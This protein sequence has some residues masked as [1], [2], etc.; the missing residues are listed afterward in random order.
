[1]RHLSVSAGQ[2]NA[3]L[4]FGIPDDAATRNRTPTTAAHGT[5]RRQTKW[6]N[7]IRYGGLRLNFQFTDFR[8]HWHL[9]S[10]YRPVPRR[11]RHHYRA[12][13]GTASA[14]RRSFNM[15]RATDRPI[16]A[17]TG[18]KQ[19][20]LCLCAV[21]L[22][23]NPHVV[24]LG[25]FKYEDERGSTRSSGAPPTSIER[26]NY[27]YTLQIAGEH[28]QSALLQ[29]RQRP[30]GQ[31]PLWIC[32]HASRV[33]C[34][35][36]RSSFSSRLAK[37]DEAA[38]QLRQRHQGAEHLQ[39]EQSRSSTCC[40][41]LPNG[42]E[43]I[44]QFHVGPIGPENSRTYDGGVDQQ[45]W[46][47]RARLGLTYFHNEFTNGVEYVPQSALLALGFPARAIPPSQYGATINSMAFRAQGAEAELEYK[48]GSHLFA[49]GGYTYLDAVVQRSF[50]SSSAPVKNPGSSFS[51]IPIGQYSPLVGARPFR[52]APHSGYF[53]LNYTRSR[54]YGSL[55]GTLVGTAR[56]QHVSLGRK[57]RREPAPAQPQPARRV[58]A[59]R[60]Q[61][62]LRA[63]PR[64]YCLRRRPESSERT[65]L[66]GLWLSCPAADLPGWPQVQLR[67]R[68]VERSII[69]PKCRTAHRP[70]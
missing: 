67:R 45:L 7:Q 60:P 2:P 15:A 24:A 19:A 47:G 3:I 12:R 51:T 43:L 53:G 26:G 32:C 4:L 22:S 35:L 48:V 58:P 55:T 64:A 6:H 37:R 27:S 42:S 63:Q 65:L 62:R 5:T 21:G 13:T 34:L 68:V 10:R 1:M 29:R 38:L 49:R 69:S 16:P 52:R 17:A 33:A 23:L 61:R 20:R 36:P 25:A 44:A 30:R 56:R 59:T 41:R 28:W 66:R 8:A 46:N 18:P 70:A 9:Q 50:S 31:W 40:P 14:V 54:W 39:P 57:L 11:S